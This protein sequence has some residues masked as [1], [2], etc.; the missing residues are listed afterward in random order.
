MNAPTT[1]KM[2]PNSASPA[3]ESSIGDY[4]ERLARIKDTESEKN[5]IVTVR[6]A[7]PL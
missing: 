6:S 7:C 4:R 1:V 3:P 5:E 2:T